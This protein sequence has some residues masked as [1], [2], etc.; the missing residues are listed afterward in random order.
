MPIFDEQRMAWY[1]HLPGLGYI[2]LKGNPVEKPRWP[3][4]VEFVMAEFTEAE[5]SDVRDAR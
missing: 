4:E 1:M 3:G 2:I 5:A